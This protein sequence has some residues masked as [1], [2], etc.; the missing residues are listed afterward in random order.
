[1]LQP[2]SRR[3]LRELDESPRGNNLQYIY[4]SVLAFQFLYS[5]VTRVCTMKSCWEATGG[6]LES[7]VR[8]SLILQS[9]TTQLQDRKQKTTYCLQLSTKR[10]SGKQRRYSTVVGTREDSSIS[11]SGRDMAANI[12]SGNLPLKFPHQN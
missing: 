7:C 6:A 4:Y 2:T 3:F 12:I 10:Q 9:Q 5:L 1:M 8:G 11:S